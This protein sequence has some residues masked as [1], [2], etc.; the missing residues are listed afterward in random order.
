MTW[1]RLKAGVLKNK[2]ERT[3]AAEEAQAIQANLIKA[4]PEHIWNDSHYQLCKIR[5]ETVEYLISGSRKIA[6]LNIINTKT[7]L[8]KLRWISKHFKFLH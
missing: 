7:E 4:K 2:S 1:Q 8:Q 3:I 6:N 5:D